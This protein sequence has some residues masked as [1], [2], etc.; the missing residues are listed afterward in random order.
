MS[1]GQFRPNSWPTLGI[2]LELQ[3]VDARSLALRSG[4]EPLLGGLPAAL[5]A[6]VK[7]EFLQCYVE[8]NSDVCRTVAD[9]RSDL[10]SKVRGVEA[11]AARQGIWLLWAGT[12]PFSRWQEQQITPNDRYFRL[13]ELLQ[14]TVVRPVTFGLHVHVG[15]KSGDHAARVI[16]RLTPH[17]PLLLALSA[18]SPFWQG[19]LTGYRS[20]RVELLECFPTGGLPPRLEG[21]E[22]YLALVRQMVAGGFIDSARDLWWDARPNADH[23]TLEVRLC[24]MPPDLPSVLGLAALIQCLVHELSEQVDRGEPCLEFHPLLVRQNRWRA[25]RYGLDAVLVDPF[26]LQ[27]QPVRRLGQSLIER[28]SGAARALGC[29]SEFEHVRQMLAA[30]DGAER[31][32]DDYR[33][34]GSLVEVVRRAIDRGRLTAG[35][36]LAGGFSRDD[37]RG[38]RGTLFPLSPRTGGIV[39]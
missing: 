35:S 6:S 14:E 25:C 15:V 34:T 27:S 39:V 36:V 16:D 31:Q 23:G 24:D 7:P 8:I 1:D 33:R 12:H 4:I 26:T 11:A 9:M 17:L 32:M 19:R 22:E 28:L 21:W 18:N 10:E 29:R 20:H 30:P 2:E 38:G 37:D 13:A 5:R 3:L